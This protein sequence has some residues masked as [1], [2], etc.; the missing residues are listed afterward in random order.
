MICLPRKKA[1]PMMR[2]R[3][4]WLTA[5]YS[6]KN[7][8]PSERAFAYERKLDAMKYL[9]E[10]SGLTCVKVGHKPDGMKSRDI[11]AEQVGQSKTQV[12]KYIRL[13]EIILEILDMV[14]GKKIAFNPAYDLSYQIEHNQTPIPCVP[15]GCAHEN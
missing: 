12:Q 15:Q 14:D 10:R 1:T 9:G 11:L 4:S 2:Q 8:L 5:T 7:L 3:L 6:V 13:I